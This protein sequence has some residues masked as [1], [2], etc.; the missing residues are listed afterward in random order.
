MLATSEIERPTAPSQA[1]RTLVGSRRRCRPSGP[2]PFFEF[3][4]NRGARDP[5]ALRGLSNVATTARNGALSGFLLNFRKGSNT[6]WRCR[7]CRLRMS[8]LMRNV[9]DCGFWLDRRLMSL[10]S[11]SIGAMPMTSSS[12]SITFRWVNNVVCFEL[13]TAI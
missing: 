10:A 7:P 5:K 2:P 9:L 1:H 12:R 13:H 8:S 6:F 4:I 3:A 11:V